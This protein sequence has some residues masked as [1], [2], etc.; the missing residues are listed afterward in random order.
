M[1]LLVAALALVLVIPVAVWADVR[2]KQQSHTDEYYYSGRLTPAENSENEMWIGEGKMAY[3]E[4]NRQ[5]IVDTNKNTLTFVNKGDSSYVEAELPF[6][7]SK[8]V[9][10]SMVE[11][12]AMY[13]TH[14][15]F[16]ASP[17]GEKIDGRDS[18][19]YEMTTWIDTES[20]KYNESDSKFCVT[21]ELPVDWEQFRAM[22]LHLL[23]L[24]N[25]DE[26]MVAA[27]D[28]IH[29]FVV[30]VEA[31]RYIH[32]F[33]V[34]SIEEVIEVTETTAPEGVYT[35]PES[36]NKKQFLS[37]ADLRG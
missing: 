16:G 30:R 18:K 31:D 24:Q 4:R 2:I 22:N 27:L 29:G 11:M 21:S 19:C 15:T 34:K 12:L 5:V 8:F 20:G 14:G 3:I 9:P 17:T 26:D 32:G 35:V 6:E 1:K 13:R 36:F 37:M 23:K 25:Y 10:E 33:S 28:A 7:W